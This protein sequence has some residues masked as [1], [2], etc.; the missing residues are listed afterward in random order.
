MCLIINEL[1]LSHF[2]FSYTDA[3]ALFFWNYEMYLQMYAFFCFWHKALCLLKK[4]ISVFIIIAWLKAAVTKFHLFTH[5]WKFKW[6]NAFDSIKNNA[7]IPFP[8]QSIY[9]YTFMIFFEL[10]TRRK[11]KYWR[12]NKY[13]RFKYLNTKNLLFKWIK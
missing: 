4:W 12:T 2:F 10:Q 9:L 5:Q 3:R 7:H 6:M 8:C 11:K 13:I 1:K